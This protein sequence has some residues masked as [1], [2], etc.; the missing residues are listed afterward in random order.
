[1]INLMYDPPNSK[2]GSIPPQPPDENK[3]TRGH[4]HPHLQQFKSAIEY[5]AQ[6]NSTYEFK[7]VLTAHTK[8]R[9]RHCGTMNLSLLEEQ[10]QPSTLESWPSLFSS[11]KE[12]F[13][14]ST[15]NMY[16]CY[17]VFPRCIILRRQ[18][19]QQQPCYYLHRKTPLIV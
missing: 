13:R 6:N 12:D 16:F 1:M 2:P 8:C 11:K 4:S 7:T 14:L 10:Q 19:L 9:D 15:T 17:L 3:S 18:E 5:V